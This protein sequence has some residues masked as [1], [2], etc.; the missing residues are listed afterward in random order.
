MFKRPEIG[1]DSGLEVC[2]A[3]G[4]TSYTG[5]LWA[6]AVFEAANTV[7]CCWILGKMQ[8]HSISKN[9]CPSEMKQMPRS[10]GVPF[11]CLELLFSCNSD[12]RAGRKN[13]WTW[14]NTIF[15]AELK[16]PECFR[17]ELL[18]YPLQ[19]LQLLLYSN[20]SEVSSAPMV[21]CT[22]MLWKTLPLCVLAVVSDFLF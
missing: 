4:D 21:T 19:K 12:C 22:I 6:T 8:V 15:C 9:P 17:I 16:V 20:F 18:W 10:F 14:F 13:L 3:S 7:S 5:K 1:A 2:I 11:T